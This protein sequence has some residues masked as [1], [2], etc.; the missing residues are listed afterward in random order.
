MGT[1]FDITHNPNH[2]SASA[3]ARTTA[4]APPLARRHGQV[5]IRIL[6][7]RLTGLRLD[8]EP[9]WLGTIPLRVPEP[10]PI[11]WSQG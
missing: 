10:L 6:L 5:A 3:P 7:Q 11:A 8:G 2:T 1:R 4:S 9:E